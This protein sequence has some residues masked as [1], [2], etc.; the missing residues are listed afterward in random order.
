[1]RRA[2]SRL[3]QLMSYTVDAVS[4]RV[5]KN[6]RQEDAEARERAAVRSAEDRAARRVRAREDRVEAGTIA[7]RELSE[8]HWRLHRRVRDEVEANMG[9]LEWAAERAA[10]A[11]AVEGRRRE[12]RSAQVAREAMERTRRRRGVRRTQ[13]IHVLDERRERL[14]DQRAHHHQEVQVA[15]RKRGAIVDGEGKT[16]FVLGYNVVEVAQGALLF[17]RLGGKSKVLNAGVSGGGRRGGVSAAAS[18]ESRNA[19]R[20][21][22]GRRKK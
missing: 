17:N 7:V 18:Q 21:L 13:H 15:D 6:A 14:D 9:A 2:T 19:S 1:M 11:E 10:Q 3:A 12:E 5:H 20:L 16:H 8:S 22:A 4:P